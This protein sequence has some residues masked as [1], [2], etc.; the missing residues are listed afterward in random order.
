MLCCAEELMTE[1]GV[2]LR[3]VHPRWNFG[4]GKLLE[5]V[6]AAPK[7]KTLTAPLSEIQLN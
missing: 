2:A 7:A 3:G 4:S 6:R 1:L 5:A